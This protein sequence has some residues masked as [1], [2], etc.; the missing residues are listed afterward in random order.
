MCSPV[1]DE[2][3]ETKTP[4]HQS[5]AAKSFVF[6]FLRVLFHCVAKTCEPVPLVVRVWTVCERY[7]RTTPRR[8]G[9]VHEP[10]WKGGACLAAPTRSSDLL[11]RAAKSAAQVEPFTDVALCPKVKLGFVLEH[12]QSPWSALDTQRFVKRSRRRLE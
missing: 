3:E 10:G 8:A 7:G 4:Q 12:Q 9:V 5:R 1:V 6:S 11:R 2:N